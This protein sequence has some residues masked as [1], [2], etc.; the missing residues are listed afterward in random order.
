MGGGAEAKASNYVRTWVDN[1]Q[2]PEGVIVH[3]IRMLIADHGP[4]PAVLSQLR[5][6]PQRRR[7]GLRA[8]R[9]GQISEPLSSCRVP[10]G[11]S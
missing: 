9:F 2:G 3:I 8:D 5:R 7:R 10:P 4:A 1:P 11:H 6:P